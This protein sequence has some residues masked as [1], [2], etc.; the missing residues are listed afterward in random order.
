MLQPD[1]VRVW[2]ISPLSSKLPA[3][4]LST[5]S[6]FELVRLFLQDSDLW[7]DPHFYHQSGK[8]WKQK[9]SSSKHKREDCLILSLQCVLLCILKDGVIGNGAVPPKLPTKES[10]NFHFCSKWNVCTKASAVNR[11]RQAELQRESLCETT[12]DV[13]PYCRRLHSSVFRRACASLSLFPPLSLP[14]SVSLSL[15]ALG[16]CSV[17]VMSVPWCSRLVLSFF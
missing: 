10:Q 14:L 9:C 4:V 8:F 11:A 13:K 3:L 16:L 7:E 12:V 2:Q 5:P 1:F 17:L 6:F 15:S